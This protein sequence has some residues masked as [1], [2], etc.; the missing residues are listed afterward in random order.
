MWRVWKRE[1]YTKLV[2]TPFTKD[3]VSSH[4]YWTE[5]PYQI[6]SNLGTLE[7]FKTV[8]DKKYDEWYGTNMQQYLRPETLF[9]TKFESYLN[10]TIIKK[11]NLKH[12]NY[13]QR[14]YNNLDDFY[15]NM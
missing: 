7:D 11:Q 3:E 9:G 12:K 8:I 2:G 4:L 13:E 10:S 15:D 6:S 14:K 5:N 1:G